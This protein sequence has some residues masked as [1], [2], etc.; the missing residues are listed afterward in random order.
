MNHGEF[1]AGW[2]GHVLGDGVSVCDGPQ[3]HAL[4][5][6]AV[7]L[8]RQAAMGHQRGGQL[9]GRGGV[10]ALKPSVGPDLLEGRSLLGLPLQHPGYEAVGRHR[11]DQHRGGA[12]ETS[13]V[14]V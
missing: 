6:G 9:G 1:N 4:D 7:L 11:R 13:G 12:A 2:E 5:D 14:A 3:H 8:L 10:D